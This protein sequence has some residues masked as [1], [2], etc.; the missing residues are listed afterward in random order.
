MRIIIQ[1]AHN[2]NSLLTRSSCSLLVENL[3]AL[4]KTS[5][6]QSVYFH[7]VNT[8]SEMAINLTRRYRVISNF[9]I[10]AI[11]FLLLFFS[12]FFLIIQFYYHVTRIRTNQV[13]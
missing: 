13:T 6:R 8:R 10:R 9:F 2:A 7:V 12:F 1:F 11:L 3:F 5:I 4:C